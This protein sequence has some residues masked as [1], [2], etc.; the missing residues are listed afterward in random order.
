[1][2]PFSFL[3]PVVWFLRFGGFV[4]TGDSGRRHDMRT[5]RR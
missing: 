2:I 5:G 4:P 1:M 3:S